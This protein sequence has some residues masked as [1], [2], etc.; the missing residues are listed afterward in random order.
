MSAAISSKQ[1][2][3]NS[4][5]NALLESIF[6]ILDYDGKRSIL[7][8]ANREEL[9]HKRLPEGTSSKR[10]FSDILNAMRILLEFSSTILFE[11]GRKFSLYID[12]HGST[13]DHFMKMLDDAFYGV[14]FSVERKTE[15]EIIV[16]MTYDEKD[17]PIFVDRWMG[18]FYRGVFLEAVRKSI[19]GKVEVDQFETTNE[20]LKFQICT[21]FECE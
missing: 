3:D 7:L 5:I 19:G 15:K 21:E 12:P 18:F 11:I 10:E 8:F 17:H 16:T 6:D 9:L 20:C 2:V 1:F 13:M 4:V 14:H